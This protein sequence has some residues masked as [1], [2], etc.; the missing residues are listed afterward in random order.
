MKTNCVFIDGIL[1]VWYLKVTYSDIVVTVQ[2]LAIAYSFKPIANTALPVLIVKIYA[3]YMK[4]QDQ[5]HRCVYMCVLTVYTVDYVYII[6]NKYCTS[7]A[8][9]FYW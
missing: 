5:D 9:V 7:A 4:I 2:R 8:N 3:F 1:I 6:Y